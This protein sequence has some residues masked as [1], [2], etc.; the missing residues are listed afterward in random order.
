MNARNSYIDLKSKSLELA[1]A[2]AILR[3]RATSH[4]RYLNEADIL[5][6]V[7]LVRSHEPNHPLLRYSERGNVASS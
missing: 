7:D 1:K 3:D 6:A 5:K 4:R 2:V